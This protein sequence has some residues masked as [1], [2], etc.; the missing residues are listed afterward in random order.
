[1]TRGHSHEWLVYLLLVPGSKLH[2][3]YPAVV[4]KIRP[5]CFDIRQKRELNAGRAKQ[6]TGRKTGINNKER[7][8][9]DTPSAPYGGSPLYACNH[10]ASRGKTGIFEYTVRSNMEQEKKVCSVVLTVSIASTAYRWG[11]PYSRARHKQQLL[12]LL[13]PP[14][15]WREKN[16]ILPCWPPQ[17]APTLMPSDLSPQKWV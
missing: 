7:F 15:Q 14:N 9:L 3:W 17:N 4:L 8:H 2:F 5:L 11:P 6:K 1:M 12:L 10:S 13:V 16:F